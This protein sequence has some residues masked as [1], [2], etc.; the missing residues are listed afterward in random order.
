M[1][2]RA[3]RCPMRRRH[4]AYPPSTTCCH[5]F[6]RPSDRWPA[7]SQLCYN[8]GVI[9]VHRQWSSRTRR[10]ALAVLV[11]A[12]F[13]ICLLVVV[14]FSARPM[15]TL[16]AIL[17]PTSTPPPSPTATSTAIPAATLL[18]TPTRTSTPIPTAVQPQARQF[19]HRPFDSAYVNEAS[20]FYPYGSTARG[21]YRIHRGADFPN[22][23]GVPVLCAERGRVIVAGADDRV[24]HGER[25]NFYGQLVIVQLEQDYRG[26]K[27]YVL[28]G[29]LSKVHVSFL[30]EVDAGDLLGEVGMTGVAIGPHLHLEV[31]V[32]ENSYEQTRNPEIWLRPLPDKGTVV[33][34]L[35]DGQGQPIPEHPLTFYHSE[36]P[37][38]RWQDATTYPP[39]EINPDDEFA[40]NFVLGDVPPGAYIV[41][42]YVN[43]HLY[44]K[45]ITVRA[46]EIARIAIEAT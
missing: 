8:H 24:V 1:K 45:E 26:Q 5:P 20:R 27:I 19:L 35:I 25:V 16:A 12:L 42:T 37:N 15:G 44:T 9:G 29:H 28:Y 46:A 7:V 41:K 11:S 22:P 33:G 23:S 17:Y 3:A 21:K 13:L 31:R 43:G 40:E 4:A 10:L 2:R 30:Q 14:A 39:A 34:L 38:Q 18:P 6:L 32:G 36:T